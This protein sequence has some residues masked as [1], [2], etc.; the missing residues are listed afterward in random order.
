MTHDKLIQIIAGGVML[1]FLGASGAGGHID[2]R[3]QR[4]APAWSTPTARARTTGRR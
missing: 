1:V 2:H 4:Q 3:V